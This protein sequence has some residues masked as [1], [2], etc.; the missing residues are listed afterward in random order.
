MEAVDLLLMATGGLR[1][2]SEGCNGHRGSASSV[3]EKRDRE[4]GGGKEK[5]RSSVERPPVGCHGHW[6]A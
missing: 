4:K 3:G 2:P 6:V 5:E 1:G